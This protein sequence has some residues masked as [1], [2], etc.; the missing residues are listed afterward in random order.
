[1]SPRFR[2]TLRPLALCISLAFAGLPVTLYST[3][4]QADEQPRQPTFDLPA[5][6]LASQLNL[7]A[8]QAGIY[9]AGDGALTQGK[10]SPAL[11]GQYSVEHALARLLE[12]SGLIAVRKADNRYEL[13]ARPNA[14]GAL[15][16]DATT[17]S[18]Q[19]QQ[20]SAW[21]ETRGYVARRTSTATKTDTA[22][23]ETP[24]SISVVTRE[25]M[26]A[27]GA[28]KLD[29]ALRYTAG[30]RADSGGEDNASD[31]PFLRGYAVSFTYKDGL[32]LRPVGFFGIFSEEI[33]GLERIE[34]LKGP[35]SV[36]YGQNDPGG[37]INTISKRPTDYQRGEVAIVGG[38]GNRQQG[39]VDISGP[40]NDDKTLLY[41]FVALAR[42][43]DGV[44]DHTADDRTYIAPS[45]TWQ[46]N[47]QTS[48]TVLASYQKNKAL[49]ATNIPW[50][51]VNGDSPYGRVPM[52]RFMGEPGFDHES[53][54]AKSLGYEFK[55][56]FDET[57]SLT[58]NV[59]YSD[60]DN[61]EDYLARASGLHDGA[62]GSINTTIDREYQLR[63]AYG[64]LLAMDNQLQAKFTTGPVEHTALAGID[65]SWSNAV[66]DEKWGDGPELN[67]FNPVYGQPVDTRVYTSWI[68]SQ[69][70]SKQLGYYLQDQLKYDQWVMTLGGRQDK[71]SA[72]TKDRWTGAE[73]SD[74]HWSAFTGRA[75]LVYLFDNGL[76]PYISYAESFAPVSGISSPAHGSKAF[77]PETG[78]Q[79]EVGIRYQPPGSDSQ[80][81]LSVYDLRKQNAL[82]SDP[83][84]FNDSVQ[85]GET[86]SKGIE[87]EAVAAVTEAL[88]VTESYSY[89]DVTVT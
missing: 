41:R 76:A 54:E 33:Y 48:L 51:A 63:H 75:G 13:Q 32:R 11:Q 78:K 2:F 29:Q 72:R 20:E 19:G 40:L 36:L 24:Q 71:A 35:S 81:T 49:A 15:E 70:R 39:N 68:N 89:S 25:R 82:T 79:Y 55:H 21:G 8:A 56:A 10:R 22:L 77:D 28:Q 43:A 66:R 18:G 67:V 44:F 5:G 30:V 88:K 73:Q 47:E 34:V 85:T 69:Q 27:I 7:L 14:G 3:V 52:H 16:L 80:V 86:R 58:Q 31:N 60:F 6:P 9:L 1:M 65:Y 74:E 50:A 61:T 62:D 45:L 26:D 53:V 46:P 37:M 57:W 4:G 17:V 42:E 87:L 64:D 83:D 12:G 84:N 38:S 23:I 59:R